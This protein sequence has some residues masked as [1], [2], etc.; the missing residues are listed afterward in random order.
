ASAGG[1]VPAGRPG[2]NARAREGRLQSRGH[3]ESLP[4]D[5]RDLARSRSFRPAARRCAGGNGEGL[6]PTGART[7][8]E[9][10]AQACAG[11]RACALV[12]LLLAAVLPAHA[13]PALAL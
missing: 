1:G 8:K 2:V 10:C 12:L 13:P 7:G 6:M 4:E 3:G 11:W 9:A 5:Q